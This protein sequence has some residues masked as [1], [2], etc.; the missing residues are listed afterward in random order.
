VSISKASYIVAYTCDGN[1]LYSFS[2]NGKL[3]KSIAV[4]ERLHVI[5]LS[6]D[7]R[8][9]ITGGMRCLIVMRWVMTLLVAND[10][11]RDKLEAVLDGEQK[12]NHKELWPPFGSPIRS[13][14]LTPGEGHLIVGLESGCVR[15]LA[16]DS[17]YLRERLHQKLELTGFLK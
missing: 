15:I 3:I 1:I 2:I 5:L 4:G 12:N 17:E 8:V 14:F 16:Q 6:E 13:L 9:I 10:G 7:G 11:P